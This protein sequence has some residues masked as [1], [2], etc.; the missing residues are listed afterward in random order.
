MSSLPR[1]MASVGTATS[2][3]LLPGTA[4]SL[5]LRRRRG[6]LRLTRSLRTLAAASWRRRRDAAAGLPLELLRL[7][8][9]A[10]LG[11]CSLSGTFAAALDR[12]CGGLT[13]PTT[14]ARGYH[15]QGCHAHSESLARTGLPGPAGRW[16]FPGSGLGF[17]AG[18]ALDIYIYIYI[19]VY[20]YI[21]THIHIYIYIYTQP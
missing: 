4:P 10:P 16:P 15:A 9:R 3:P 1:P 12:W 2:L 6:C 11:R 14:R 17:R 8:P 21:Y 7:R 13:L 19:Y 20:I 18:I 5:T